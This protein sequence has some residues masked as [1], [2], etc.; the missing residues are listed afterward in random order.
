M[1]VPEVVV[2]TKKFEENK[3]KKKNSKGDKGN[4]EEGKRPSY[5]ISAA[6]GMIIRS[7]HIS[8]QCG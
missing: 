7:V 2:V 3:G 5:G 4:E 6:A 1:T 8:R